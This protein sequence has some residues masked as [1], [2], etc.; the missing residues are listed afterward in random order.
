MKT[1][2]MKNQSSAN[3]SR[4]FAAKKAIFAHEATRNGSSRIDSYQESLIDLLA[5]LQHFC[6]A[7][8]IYF[9]ECVRM[10]RGNFEAERE[11]TRNENN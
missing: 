4:I 8:D 6:A 7:N 1:K 2:T 3:I 11:R 10:A 9:H 5:D